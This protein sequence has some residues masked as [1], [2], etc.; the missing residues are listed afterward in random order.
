MVH[1][2]ASLP[3]RTIVILEI[4]QESYRFGKLGDDWT[5]LLEGLR[6]PACG[7]TRLG[8]HSSYQKYLYEQRITIQRLRCRG[9]HGNT[10]LD[11]WALSAGEVRYLDASDDLDEVF[12][13]EVKRRVMNDRTV[14]LNGR[15]Y[16]VDALLVGQTVTLRYDP[17]VPPT[18]PLQVRHNGADA[19]LATILDAYA[20]ASVKRARPSWQIESDCPAPQ[21][22]TVTAGAAQTRPQQGIRLMYLRHFTFTR[23]PFAANLE[24]DELFAS[25]ARREAEARLR[26]LLELRGIG[27]LT[28]EVGCGKTTVCRHVTAN[29]HPGL[30]RVF[31]RLPLHRQRS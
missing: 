29:L 7:S 10:P 11:Q 9:L 1:H 8:H 27:L 24:A 25:V 14:S 23:F 4:S 15:L 30:H 12:L 13:F 28:G 26:H 6:C 16:E 19:G 2:P 22:A 21:P 17:G 3:P 18:R 31:L 5:S 20:N